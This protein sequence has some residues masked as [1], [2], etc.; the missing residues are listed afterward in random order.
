MG[1]S[2]SRSQSPRFFLLGI[3]Y[4]KHL[5]YA[6]KIQDVDHLRDHIIEAYQRIDGVEDLLNRVFHNFH[7]RL[8]LCV[9]SKGAHFEHMN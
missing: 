1:P 3:L 5:V 4:V 2:I 9:A 6:V 7:Y 8:T